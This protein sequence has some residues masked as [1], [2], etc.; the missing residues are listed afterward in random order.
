MAHPLLIG[1]IH[2]PPLETAFIEEATAK[3]ANP[4][5]AD[6]AWQDQQ[7]RGRGA[8]S[9]QL[10]LPGALG[11]EG[12]KLNTRDLRRREYPGQMRSE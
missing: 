1:S 8:T 2:F 12:S 6:L 5:G 10:V 9:H 3:T 4:A 11:L 7:H